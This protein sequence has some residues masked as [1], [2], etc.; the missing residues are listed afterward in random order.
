MISKEPLCI[1]LTIE[2]LYDLEVKVAD[3]VNTFVMAPNRKEMWI[4]GQDFKDDSSMF[5]IFV[6]AL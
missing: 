3:V 5:V 4:L 1:A 6:R 2:A